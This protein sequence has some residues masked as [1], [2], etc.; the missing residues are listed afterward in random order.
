MVCSELSS[1]FRIGE[2]SISIYTGIKEVLRASKE[3]IVETKGFQTVALHMQI[4]SLYLQFLGQI[5]RLDFFVA[6]LYIMNDYVLFRS[7]II[8][9][10]LEEVI[11]VIIS[12]K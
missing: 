9:N 4:T 1:D 7:P 6:E 5:L 8:K 11:D 10:L 12:I 3:M 2:L